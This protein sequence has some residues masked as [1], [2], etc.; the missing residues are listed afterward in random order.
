MRRLPCLLALV[1]TSSAVIE[2]PHPR[3]WKGQREV[4]TRI[5]SPLRWAIDSLGD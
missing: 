5:A 2:C 4:N 3:R 1:V